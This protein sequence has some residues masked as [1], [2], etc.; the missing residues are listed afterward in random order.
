MK[1][2]KYLTHS[3][4]AIKRTGEIVSRQDFLDWMTFKGGKI[5]FTEY[6]GPLIGLKENWEEQ[7]ATPEE[8]DFSAFRYRIPEYFNVPADC[9][10]L[11]KKREKIYQ[12]D[13]V[14]RYIDDL[15]CLMEL[16]SNYATIPLPLEYPVKT[17]DDWLK[18]KPKYQFD[19]SR[20]APGWLDECRQ[21]ERQGKVIAARIP[22]GFD[23]PRQLMGEEN[24]CYACYEN[25]ELVHDII[26]TIS[27]TALR[28]ME[29]VS[30]ACTVDM[31]HVHEDMAGKSGP[32]W[33]PREIR[34][35]IHPY[36]RRIRDLLFS[37]GCRIFD[38]DSDGYMEPVIGAFIEAGV[39]CM[40]PCEPAAGMDIVRIRRQWGDKLMLIGGI[41]KF[42]LT[43][44]KDEIEQELEYKV[45]AMIHSGG[46]CILSADHR[47]PAEVTLENYRFYIRKVWEII[48]REER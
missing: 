7:H 33:G 39:N 31:L 46:G 26:D 15:G 38:Q 1:K 12:D 8:L 4:L 16:Q 28:V 27:E 20:F 10:R 25:P 36:Y 42:A 17:M 29:R 9:G 48:S 14:I 21:A 24:L 47:L 30:D 41:D 45:P 19:E 35:F 6:F 32:L 40:H 3:D 5:L 11:G 22:G 13:N 34:E 37:R 2:L 18:I 43:R 23:E 44:T